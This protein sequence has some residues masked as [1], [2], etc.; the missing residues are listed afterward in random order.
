MTLLVR[1][2]GQGP[3]YHQIYCSLRRDILEGRLRPGTRL[4]ATRILAADLSVSRTTVVLAYRQLFVE[5]YITGRVG[6]GSFVAPT[7]PETML[8]PPDR[9]P[10]GE[11]TA[12]ETSSAKDKKRPSPLSA[13][14]KQIVDVSP[15]PVP[16]QKKSHTALRYDFKI[17]QPAIEE[18]PH[19]T[20]RRLVQRRVRSLS[21]LSLNYGDPRGYSPLRGAIAEYLDRARAVKCR[22]EQVVVVTGSQQALDLVTRIL[23]DR[24]DKVALEDPHYQGAR[25]IFLSHGASLIPIPVDKEGLRVDSL[26]KRRSETENLKMVYLTPSHQFPTGAVLPLSRRLALLGWAK[27]HDAFILE[28]DYDSEFRYGERPVESLQGLDREGRVIYVGTFSKVLYPALRIGYLV[29]PPSLLPSLTA[30]K[31]LTDRHTPSLEQEALADFV[32]RGH[33][34]RHLR[35]SRL[36]NA[37]RRDALLESLEHHF[38]KDVK[39]SGT[40]SGIHVLVELRTLRPSRLNALAQKAAKAGVGIYPITPYCINPPKKAAFLLGYASLSEKQIRDGIRR[41]AELMKKG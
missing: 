31:W 6:S 35:R 23:V 8:S 30:A 20:W 36:R 9:R 7:L 24:G 11:L 26:P 12:S 5:G 10:V 14:G 22:P 13:Y 34:E 29:L 4:P 32:S 17:G 33:F 27:K 18:F 3:K 21:V 39:I 15:L 38:G 40:R 41:L 16:G 1:L 25:Q 19:E 37:S 28:D 2:R